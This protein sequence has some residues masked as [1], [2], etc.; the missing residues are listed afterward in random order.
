MKV[1]PIINRVEFIDKKKFIKVA[2]DRNFKTFVV[3]I[4]TLGSARILIHSS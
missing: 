2:L 3:Y 1:L 4:A